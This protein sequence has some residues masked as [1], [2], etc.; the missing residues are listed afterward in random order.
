MVLFFFNRRVALDD[1]KWHESGWA[2][3]GRRRYSC[4]RIPDSL[5]LHAGV[6][7][8][9]EVPLWKK[10][11][12][13]QSMKATLSQLIVPSKVF[14]LGFPLQGPTCCLEWA[15]SILTKWNCSC[16][17]HVV[18]IC[19]CLDSGLLYLIS[20]VTII[21]KRTLQKSKKSAWIFNVQLMKVTSACW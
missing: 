11:V 5:M 21:Q 12:F 19:I 6:Y 3:A 4:R 20:A 16:A 7:F 9:M 2:Q 15:V 10:T 14:T 13:L 1:C 8:K 17:A 18:F